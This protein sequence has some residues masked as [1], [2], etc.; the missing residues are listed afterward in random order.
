MQRVCSLQPTGPYLYDLACFQSSLSGALA[1][2]GS[3]LWAAEA[4][5]GAGQAM[6]TLRR[7]VAA[8]YRNLAWMRGDA[9]LDPL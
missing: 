5:A 9:D 1:S 4:S 2:P 6:D 3:P 7:A 8:G